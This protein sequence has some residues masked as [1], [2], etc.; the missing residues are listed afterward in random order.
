MYP[1]VNNMYTQQASGQYAQMGYSQ[2]MY[3]QPQVSQSIFYGQPQNVQYPSNQLMFMNMQS[4]PAQQMPVYGETQI[5]GQNL[6]TQQSE[7]ALLQ[8]LMMIFMTMMQLMIAILS[9]M[10]KAKEENGT[11]FAEGPIGPVVPGAA[12]SAAPTAWPILMPSPSRPSIP[13][14]I[15]VSRRASTRYSSI[16]MLLA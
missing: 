9:K 6:Q 4:G 16:S 2:G 12:A 7:Q 1:S 11:L 8:P 10:A 15:I 5:Q 14:T 13:M 3:A